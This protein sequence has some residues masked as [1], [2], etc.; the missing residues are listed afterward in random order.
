MLNEDAG[1]ADI[2]RATFPSG[3]VTGAPKIST[4]KIIQELEPDPRGV[5]TGALGYMR[6]DESVFNVAIRTVHLDLK[7]QTLEMGTGGGILYEADTAREYRECEL[8]AQFLT[9]PYQPFK[10]FETLLWDPKDGFARCD[11]HLDRML[12]SAAYFLFPADR[13]VLLQA[14]QSESASWPGAT[15][16]LRVRLLLDERGRIEVQAESLDP[17]PANP[18]VCVSQ[19]RVNSAD[20]FLFHKTTN[21][22]FYDAEL[23]A[24]RSRNCFDVLFRNERDEITEG[25]VSNIVIRKGDAWLTPPVDCGLLA[26][27]YR[28]HLLESGRLREEILNMKDLEAAD[29]IFLTNALRGLLP[30]RLV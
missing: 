8:K 18:R 1:T 6:G 9:E 25:A 24:A 23:A 16:P 30:V 20:R 13:L 21:R 7:S 2:F 4:M 5:Y 3:S 29:E 22:A 14:L 10:L 19:L 11:L 17:A 26:G 28:R 27:T 12:D 15:Q